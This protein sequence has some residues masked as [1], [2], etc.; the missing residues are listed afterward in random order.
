MGT[1]VGPFPS[2]TFFS[3]FFIIPFIPFMAFGG[4]FFVALFIAAL[5]LFPIDPSMLSSV[6]LPLSPLPFFLFIIFLVCC[7]LLLTLSGPIFNLDFS[8][9]FLFT[10]LGCVSLFRLPSSST[11]VFSCF[12]VFFVSFCLSFLAAPPFLTFFRLETPFSFVAYIDR[13]RKARDAGFSI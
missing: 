5:S 2:L 3:F 8:F 7:F 10:F 13:N 1:G 12:V 11:T 6:A 4:L 9:S